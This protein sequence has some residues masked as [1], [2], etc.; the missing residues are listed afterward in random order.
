M[1]V[2]PS[3][4]HERMGLAS[5]DQRTGHRMMV[6]KTRMDVLPNGSLACRVGVLSRAFTAAVS[7]LLKPFGVTPSQAHLFY[8][9]REGKATPTEIAQA[10]GVEPSSVSRLL[11]TMEKR[12]LVRREIDGADRTRINVTLSE[13]GAEL[14]E[15]ID[16]HAAAIEAAAQRALAPS[17]LK[18][19]GEWMERIARELQMVP[20]DASE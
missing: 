1:T 18:Q 4:R 7:R 12:D 15:R 2:G 16:F 3:S 19:F 20:K 10:M 11:G 14:A 9:L 5:V 17:E 13:D 8:E 6:E